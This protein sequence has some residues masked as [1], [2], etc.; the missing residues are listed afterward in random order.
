ME[1]FAA[2]IYDLGKIWDT[3]LYAEKGTFCRIQ[4][5]N[6]LDIQLESDEARER[7]LIATFLCDVPPGAYREMLFKAAMKANGSYPRHGVLAYSER[8]NKLTLFDYAYTTSLTA[9]KLALQLEKFIKK[10]HEWK[11]AVEKSLP[12]PVSFDEPKKGSIFGL[13]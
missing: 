10:A 4:Y 3:D 12:L 13:K 1:K 11:E 2:L 9:E 8:N 5:K 7:I 6:Q